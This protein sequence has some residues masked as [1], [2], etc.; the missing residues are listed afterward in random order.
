MCDL[1]AEASSQESPKNLFAYSCSC[2]GKPNHA[3]P[4]CWEK[5][6]E[7]APKALKEKKSAKPSVPSAATAAAV[8]VAAAAPVQA[9]VLSQLARPRSRRRRRAA[10]RVMSPRIHLMF[11][12][13]HPS[14]VSL[15]IR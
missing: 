11:P 15:R 9:S 8:T 10:S 12:L 3:E 7:R 6:P 13:T 1:N 14:G 5:H 4:N 2:C